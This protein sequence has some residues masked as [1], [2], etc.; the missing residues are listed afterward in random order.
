ME[1]GML[2][3]MLA[4]AAVGPVAPGQAAARQ[5]STVTGRWLTE[6]H[7]GVV[8]I[9]PCGTSICG[10]LIDGEIIRHDPQTRDANNKDATQRQRP[11]K[12]LMMLHG[13]HPAGSRW[14]GGSVYNPEDGG[15]YH[16]TLTIIDSQTLKVR[17][18]IV[19]PLCKSQAWKR[20]G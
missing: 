3:I 14:D 16:G 8:E 19:W 5:A 20:I 17:G 4:A 12:G 15:T 13:F 2:A 9:T 1:K 7:H 6:T 11:L 18:C 10:R